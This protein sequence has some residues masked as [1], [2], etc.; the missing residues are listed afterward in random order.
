MKPKRQLLRNVRRRR[1]PYALMFAIAIVLLLTGA[2]TTFRAIGASALRTMAADSA[3]AAIPSWPVDSSSVSHTDAP[4]LPSRADYD[5]FAAEDRAWRERHARV[6]SVKELRARG[7]GRR[8]PREM[9][10]DRVYRFQRAG[11]RDR[12]IAE[13]TQWGPARPRDGTAV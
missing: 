10:E 13:R 8:T 5:R 1:A 12:A 6:L 4:V 3:A 2:V 7:D 9:M 11:Q